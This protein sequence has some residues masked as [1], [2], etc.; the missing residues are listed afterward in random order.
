MITEEQLAYLSGRIRAIEQEKG[1]LE[2]E[3]RISDRERDIRHMLEYVE[4][5]IML[6]KSSKSINEEL[7]SVR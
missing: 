5:I 4:A 3:F 1:R 2:L 7:Q 6:E